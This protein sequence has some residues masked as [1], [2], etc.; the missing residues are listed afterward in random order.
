[1]DVDQFSERSPG[2]HSNGG[3]VIA[4][5]RDGRSTGASNAAEEAEHDPLRLGGR[6]AG[7]KY[8]A[9]DEQKIDLLV[10]DEIAEIIKDRLELSQPVA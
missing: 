8:V 9:G 2:F 1:M 4:G 5:D 7:V 3:I 10:L 6:R